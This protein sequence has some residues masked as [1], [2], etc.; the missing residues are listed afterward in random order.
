MLDAYGERLLEAVHRRK[1]RRLFIDGLNGLMKA[2]VEPGR[3]DHFFTALANELRVLGVTT[4]YSLEVPDI[5]GPAIRVPIDD[6]S[7]I[8]ENMILLRFI[9]LR[10]KLYRLIS[11]L[12]VRNSDFDPSLHQYRITNEGIEIEAT[13][14]SAESIMSGFAQGGGGLSLTKTEA[15]PPKHGA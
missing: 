15:R 10:S 12:K 1:V 11:I 6:I 3:M 9:E 8:A 14:D 4:L 2:A 7:S 13:A 5:L